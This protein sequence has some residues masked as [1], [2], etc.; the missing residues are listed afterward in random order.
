MHVFRWRAAVL[1]CLVITARSAAGQ[2]GSLEDLT[3]DTASATRISGFGVAGLQGDTVSG[4]TRFDAGKLAVGVFRELNEQ[5]WI[6]GQLTTSV[7]PGSEGQDEATTE[8]EIDNLIVNVSPRSDLSVSIGKLD[9]PLGFERDDEPLN[10]QATT[11]HNFELARPPKLVGALVRWTGF[12]TLDLAGWVAN[13]WS[14]DLEPNRGKTVGGRLGVRPSERASIGA[15]FL[16]GPEGAEG[17][18]SNRYLASV[19]Y[20]VQ[21]DDRWLIAG[22]LNYGGDAASNTA[23]AAT[24]YGGTATV[25]RQ[26]TRAFGIAGRFDR[27]SDPDGARSGVPQTLHS[28]TISPVYFVGT[29]GEGIFATIEHTTL[30]I[31][32]FQIRADLRWDHAS[33]DGDPIERTVADSAVAAGWPMTGVIQLVATF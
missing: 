25:F 8:I 5:T 23:A 29:G 1:A 20:A 9:M 14:G 2:T 11:S 12:R 19:D 4:R 13:G 6:F 10:L 30:R 27:F 33:V 28:L 31:P 18:T 32:R 22:E 3:E 26:V 7:S 17:S 24:W 16:F 15:G 21:P